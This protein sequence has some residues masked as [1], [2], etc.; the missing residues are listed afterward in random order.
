MLDLPKPIC[1]VTS[2]GIANSEVRRKEN[3]INM[4]VDSKLTG[5]FLAF[6]GADIPLLPPTSFADTCKLLRL[7][8]QFEATNEHVNLVRERLVGE[9][10]GKL[11]ELLA[12]ASKMDDRNLG[13]MA[14]KEMNLESFSHG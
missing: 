2:D 1:D 12:F 4:E 9:S 10:K 14:L 8:D 7:C 11:W 6:L 3:I 5:Y 13:L